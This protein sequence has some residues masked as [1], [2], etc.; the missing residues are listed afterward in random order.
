[1]SK[2]IIQIQ[3]P[4]KFSLAVNN[5]Y[6]PR[7]IQILG[8]AEPEKIQDQADVFSRE[9]R[10]FPL[11][12]R[13]DVNYDEFF[14]R[15]TLNELQD[16]VF[17]EEP[18]PTEGEAAKDINKKLN[19][20][21]KKFHKGD[22]VPLEYMI[23]RFVYAKRQDIA[24][25]NFS[26]VVARNNYHTIQWLFEAL[27]YDS[28]QEYS[29][30][31]EGLINSLYQRLIGEKTLIK[32]PT[33]IINTVVGEFDITEANKE[34]IEKSIENL[35]KQIQEQQRMLAFSQNL[36][37]AP[38]NLNVV[39]P[40][41]K[42]EAELGELLADNEDIE[43]LFADGIE[44]QVIE[45]KGPWLKFGTQS[46]GRGRNEALAALKNSVSLREGIK[47]ATAEKITTTDQL[48][49]A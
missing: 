33:K 42:I 3:S 45:Q 2:A 9:F 37:K 16:F 26:I 13:K 11:R 30:I 38:E 7:L 17:F 15:G 28:K 8:K 14:Y 41:L 34:H 49:V 18:Y 27:F 40:P 21:F 4:N 5:C 46:L 24:D 43:Q 23:W 25:G 35:Q 32:R 10:V 44:A 20:H 19:F 6:M 48:V 1:M 22:I 12:I 29:L 47:A 39:T 36:I 31:T